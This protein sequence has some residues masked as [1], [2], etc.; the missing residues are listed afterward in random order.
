MKRSISSILLALLL[1]FQAQAWSWT[2]DSKN[3][4]RLGWGDPMFETLAFH[5]GDGKTDYHYTGHF[6]TEYQRL[7]TY[8]F[9]VGVKVDWENVNWKYGSDKCNFYNLSI[10]PTARFTWFQRDWCS[11]HSSIG[12]GLNIN[13]GTEVDYLGRK[14]VAAPALDLCPVGFSVYKDR[15]FL[16]LELG[17]LSSL[18]NGQEIFMFFSR[19][20]SISAGI[21]F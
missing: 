10:L 20:I 14:T 9:S 1:S 3:E 18:N 15:Y 6:F 7:I 17:G 4:V 21:N 8:K 5:S 2:G 16:S 13:G 19:M 12:A 11:L